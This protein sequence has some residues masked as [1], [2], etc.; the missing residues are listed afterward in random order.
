MSVDQAIA[1]ANAVLNN[2][3]VGPLVNASS[4]A[5]ASASR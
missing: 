2:L 1:R 4:A 5:A 3:T